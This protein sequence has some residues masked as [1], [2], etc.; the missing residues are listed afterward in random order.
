MVHEAPHRSV[1][2]GVLVDRGLEH[3]PAPLLILVDAL[4]HHA[5]KVVSAALH[6]V[7]LPLLQSL[8]VLFGESLLGEEFYSHIAEHVAHPA[9]EDVM[10]HRRHLF[11]ARADVPFPPE[12]A[13]FRGLLSYHLGTDF[14]L[15]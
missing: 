13:E 4:H 11:L 2:V 8:E 12:L 3:G 15:I 1:D 6:V 10:P 5:V 14:R 7:H 9:C